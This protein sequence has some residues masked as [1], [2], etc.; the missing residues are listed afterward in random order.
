ML[1]MLLSL[2]LLH[3]FWSTAIVDVA[4]AT[5]FVDV[6]EPITA[7]AVYIFLEHSCCCCCFHCCCF[8]VFCSTVA[9]DVI[10]VAVV[11][12]PITVESVVVYSFF[13]AL[14]LS[15]L[16]ADAANVVDDADVVGVADIIDTIEP[17]SK[18]FVAKLLFLLLS[19]LLFQCFLWHFCCPCGS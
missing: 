15:V 2:L 1:L 12:D 17:V 11:V 8:L 19:L 4:D 14:Q 7:E 13:D 6:V 10:D 18:I 9:V 5:V 16:V 3:G